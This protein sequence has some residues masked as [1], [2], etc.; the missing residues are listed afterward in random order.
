MLP[1][2]IYPNEDH[3]MRQSFLVADIALEAYINDIKTFVTDGVKANIDCL[4]GSELDKDRKDAR[5]LKKDLQ[6][7]QATRYPFSYESLLLLCRIIA[8]TGTSL[9]QSSSGRVV[10]NTFLSSLATQATDGKSKKKD[11]FIPGGS[12]QHILPP[13]IKHLTAHASSGMDEDGDSFVVRMLRRSWL[14]FKINTVPGTPTQL[15]GGGRPRTRVVYNAW[16]LFG[17]QSTASPTKQVALRP[18]ERQTAAIEANIARAMEDDADGP[19]CANDLKLQD[20]HTMLNRRMLPTDFQLPA[21][22]KQEDSEYVK[23]T[24][25]K[26]F[27]DLDLEKPLHRLALMI[28]IVFSKLAPNIYTN[29]PSSGP[30]A[31]IDQEATAQNYLQTLPWSS[32]SRGGSTEKGPLMSMMTVYILA[33]YDEHSPLREYHKK[34]KK[35]GQKWTQK[36]GK[37]AVQYQLRVSLMSCQAAKE[38]TRLP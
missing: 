22:S 4:A 26:V 2:D 24:Y 34:E 32:K 30:S 31:L 12:F 3:E 29:S 20:M 33:L 11:P 28:G 10:L 37:L 15:S 18:R 16:T 23:A 9:P 19:W 27:D 35:L 14:H 36:H 7:W 25:K 13:A 17:G 5:I 6:S 8:P 1:A 21:L 38:S